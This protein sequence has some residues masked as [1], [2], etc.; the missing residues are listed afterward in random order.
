MRA[1]ALEIAWHEKAPIWSVDVSSSNRVVTAGGDKVARVWRLSPSATPPELPV[2]WLCDLRAHLTTVN[3]A[4]FSRSGLCIATGADQGEIVVW[5]LSAGTEGTG[6]PSPLEVAA[7][8]VEG[9]PAPRERWGHEATLRGHHQDVL[10]L[11]WGADG[12]TLVSASVDNTIVVWDTRHPTR[13][14]TVLRAH[15][16]YVQGVAIDPVGKIIASLGNDRALRLFSRAGLTPWAPVAVATA[17][18]SDARLFSNDTKFKTFFRRLAWSPDGSVLA[19]PSGLHF[20]QTKRMFAVHLFARNNWSL[21]AAQCGGL[22]KPACAVRFSPVL[23][24]LRRQAA[25]EE[26]VATPEAQSQSQSCTASQSSQKSGEGSVR[27]AA[28]IRQRKKFGPF[29]GFTYRMVLAVACVDAVLFYDTEAFSRPFATVEGLHCAEH[30]DIAWSADGLTVMLSS[31]DGYASVITFTEEEL[32][33]RLRESQIPRWMREYSLQ[34][35]HSETGVLVKAARVSPQSARPASCLTMIPRSDSAKDVNLGAPPGPSRNIY[36]RKALG[37]RPQP[38]HTATVIGKSGLLTP[39]ADVQVKESESVTLR[40]SSGQ[41]FRIAAIEPARSAKNSGLPG[42]SNSTVTAKSQ[43][44]RSQENL[45]KTLGAMPVEPKRL[46]VIVAAES[47]DAGTLEETKPL[48]PMTV[49]PRRLDAIV[50]AKLQD[51][52]PQEK[53]AKKVNAMHVEPKRLDAIVTPKSQDA[54]PQEKTI[55][56]LRAMPVEQKRVDAIGLEVAKTPEVKL[57]VPKRRLKQSLAVQATVVPQT[58]S[59]DKDDSKYV[60]PSKMPVAKDCAYGNMDSEGAE[61]AVTEVVADKRRPKSRS[62]VQTVFTV[63]DT[64]DLGKEDGREKRDRDSHAV[65]T[66]DREP[67]RQQTERASVVDLA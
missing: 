12:Y 23:Y 42:H 37:Q 60:I 47:K 34:R 5:R 22:M 18:T 63:G 46:D 14:P 67:K 53:A 2:D 27:E 49:D 35:Q 20:P 52:C 6:G 45:V 51:A 65:S 19:C 57:V 8:G 62:L 9:A 29:E 24:T 4:R 48:S 1:K 39:S 33:P 59:A 15:S 38:L 26:D 3:V 56:P 36:Q 50:A 41:G 28:V 44:T 7:E 43:D 30:T 10:D 11:S 61:K 58:T 32:G 40:K 25:L 21:P 31:V 16:N 64:V 66:E 55:E 54:C 17:I 13:P